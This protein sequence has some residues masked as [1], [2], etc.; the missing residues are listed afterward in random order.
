M[1]WGVAKKVSCLGSVVF[2]YNFLN[3]DFGPFSWINLSLEDSSSCIWDLI[4]VG[5]LN[6]FLRI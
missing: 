4:D 5:E 3:W 1:A 6:L 2:S